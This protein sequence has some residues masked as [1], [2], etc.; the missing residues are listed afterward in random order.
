M[1][2]TVCPKCG[3]TSGE[4]FL[5]SVADAI[6][7]LHEEDNPEHKVVMKQVA[8]F[9]SGLQGEEDSEPQDPTSSKS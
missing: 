9:G 1:W 4:T 8:T 2:K 6:G 7:R 5:Q 3:W